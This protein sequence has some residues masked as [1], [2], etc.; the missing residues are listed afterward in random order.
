MTETAHGPGRT[1]ADVDYGADL[2]GRSVS[3]GKTVG[4]TDVYL[5]A[6]ISG[7]FSP[8]HVDE[9]YMKGGRYGRR[10]AHGVLMLAYMSTCSSK[11]VESIGNH[12]HVSYGYDRVRFVNPVFIGDT[13]RV[14][15]TI[16]ERLPERRMLHAE[17][18][19]FNQDGDVVAAATHILKEV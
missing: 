7:D 18:R 6:G 2:I 1:P 9:E 13:I 17:V 8:N 10:I 19:V 14:E 3:F 5:F 15:Y 4:E 11:F 12:P 16:T